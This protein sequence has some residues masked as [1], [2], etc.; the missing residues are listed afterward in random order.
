MKI[1]IVAHKLA[2]LTFGFSSSP[3]NEKYLAS[4]RRVIGY[5]LRNNRQDISALKLRFGDLEFA[6]SKE[7]I[8]EFGKHAVSRLPKED[9]YLIQRIEGEDIVPVVGV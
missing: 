8:Q 9:K 2:D 4:I 5:N 3:E 6:P 7:T 1:D